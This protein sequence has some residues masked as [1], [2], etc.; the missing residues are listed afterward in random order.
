MSC[1]VNTNTH[2]CECPA[3]NHSCGENQRSWS[4][5]TPH[6]TL[7]THNR[8]IDSLPVSR[9]VHCFPM[10]LIHLGR[11]WYTYSIS[12]LSS[13]SS[14]SFDSGY[15]MLVSSDWCPYRHLHYVYI[16]AYVYVCSHVLVS[17]SSTLLEK[18]IISY[19]MSFMN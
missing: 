10:H 6:H 9:S 15:H 4:P 17:L 14:D 1:K 19:H 8:V 2:F 13:Y 16:Y 5:I 18:A 3:E 11:V 12:C 7:Q